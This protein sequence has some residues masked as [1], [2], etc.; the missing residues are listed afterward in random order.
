MTVTY[1]GKPLGGNNIQLTVGAPGQ[2]PV[3]LDEDMILCLDSG[4]WVA[5]R[6][7][8]ARAPDVASRIL[9]SAADALS[10]ITS[11]PRGADAA[12]L[13]STVIGAAG[14]SHWR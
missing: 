14:P 8:F 5:L 10:A 1:D 13:G 9:E 12:I 11:D 4:W 2:T 3:G 7:E 6:N